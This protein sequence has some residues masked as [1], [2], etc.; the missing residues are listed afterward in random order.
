MQGRLVYKAWAQD[1][2][3]VYEAILKAI[4]NTAVEF[5]RKTAIK[6]VA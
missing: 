3:K 5:T 4:D 1:S 6:K 2:N